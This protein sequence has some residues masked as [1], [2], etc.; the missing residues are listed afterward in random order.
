MISIRFFCSVVS[1]QTN[2]ID[3]PNEIIGYGKYYLARLKNPKNNKATNPNTKL[4]KSQLSN[5]ID[6]LLANYVTF[7][8][9]C[10]VID[11]L[12]D[13]ISLDIN[14]EKAIIFFN[15][16][17]DLLETM[18]YEDIFWN[19]YPLVFNPLISFLLISRSSQKIN[20]KNLANRALFF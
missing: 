3:I 19:K 2:L 18:V 14:K 7:E 16:A 11:F 9:I 12:P 5:I 10:S 6:L 13:I 4:I 15:Y 20:N 1:S 8:S 17:V